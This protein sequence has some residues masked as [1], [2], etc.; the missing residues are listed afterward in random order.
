[1]ARYRRVLELLLPAA[2]PAE[3]S[4]ELIAGR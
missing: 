2:L 3:A 4:A 1:V